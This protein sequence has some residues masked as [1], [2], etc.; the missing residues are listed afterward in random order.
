MDA[1][2]IAGVLNLYNRI[3]G[4]SMYLYI[5]NALPFISEQ[6]NCIYLRRR[7]LRIIRMYNG[8]FMRGVPEFHL[9]HTTKIMCRNMNNSTHFLRIR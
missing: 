2:D 4:N 1:L 3:P 6:S 9:Y 7:C 8:V 5:T